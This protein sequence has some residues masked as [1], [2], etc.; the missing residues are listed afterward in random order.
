MQDG[1]ESK[2]IIPAATEIGDV[3]VAVANS[4]I[5]APL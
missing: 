4:F 3:N 1:T 5:L 2:P